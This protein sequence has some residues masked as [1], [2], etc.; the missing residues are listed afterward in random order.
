MLSHWLTTPVHRSW[1]LKLMK[2]CL[3]C[4]LKQRSVFLT[5]PPQKP[6]F[7]RQLKSQNIDPLSANPTKRSNTLK[8]FVGKLPTNFLSVFDLFVGLVLKGLTIIT[9]N[10]CVL[11]ISVQGFTEWN[12][13]FTA[14]D[15]FHMIRQSIK[16]YIFRC[17]ILMSTW[18][19][20]K[21][22]GWKVSKYGVNSGPYFLVFGMNTEI[23]GIHL[24]IQSE[25]RK[26]RTRNNA[27]FEH[28]SRSEWSIK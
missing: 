2:C 8:K 27:V 9:G 16:F 14:S 22:T 21:V 18:R 7:L 23:Y 19:L 26:I 11:L 12:R 5:L 4:F 17:H 6:N 10:N 25:Y 24:C 13:S 20:K 15:L 1:Q 28:F 3:Y